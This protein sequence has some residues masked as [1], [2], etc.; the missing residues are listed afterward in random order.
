MFARAAAIGLGDQADDLMRRGEEGLEGGLGEGSGTDEE[1][2][3][4]HEALSSEVEGRQD[5]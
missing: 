4:G 5:D 1:D 3:K 2:A